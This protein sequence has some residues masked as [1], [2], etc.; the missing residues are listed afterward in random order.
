MSHGRHYFCRAPHRT[1]SGALP[2][3]GRA[4]APCPTGCW[5]LAHC[6]C[7]EGAA[8]RAPR[9]PFCI[10]FVCAP[11]RAPHLGAIWRI[12]LTWEGAAAS[13]PTFVFFILFAPCST[14]SHGAVFHPNLVSGEGR[15]ARCPTPPGPLD[16]AWGRSIWRVALVAGEDRPARCPTPP[17][18]LDCV[19]GWPIWRVA[20]YGM[21]GPNPSRSVGGAVRHAQ[22]RGS[23]FAVL[24][25]QY[26]NTGWDCRIAPPTGHRAHAH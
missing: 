17:G 14:P 21:S 18:P 23:R 11:C 19:W 24:C 12:A 10:L 20:P 4:V 26:Q 1:Q 13:C 8:G 5:Y 25:V 2:L 7:M 15:P 22:F 16:C 9:T 6:P 3:H